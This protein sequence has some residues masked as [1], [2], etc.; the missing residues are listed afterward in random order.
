LDA[1]LDTEWLLL[2]EDP[3]PLLLPL[4]FSILSGVT[5]TKVSHKCQCP[6][7]ANFKIAVQEF[8]KL[9]E[10]ITLKRVP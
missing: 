10:T 3:L 4:P 5:E 2:A 1:E 7:Q 6:I 8:S 9:Y